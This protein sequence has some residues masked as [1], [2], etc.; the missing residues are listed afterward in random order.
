M[1]YAP[2][3]IRKIEQLAGFSKSEFSSKIAIS[4]NLKDCE[5]LQS[6]YKRSFI[7]RSLKL[8]DFAIFEP[9]NDLFF[10]IERYGNLSLGKN[11]GSLILKDCGILHRKNSSIFNKN[12]DFENPAGSIFD[13]RMFINWVKGVIN[14]FNHQSD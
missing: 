10:E 6:K 3:L 4:I 14:H 1:L 8:K 9:K 13:I 7:E 2:I 12:L 5:I 11:A